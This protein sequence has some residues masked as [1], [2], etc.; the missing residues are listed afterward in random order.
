MD[1]ERKSIFFKISVILNSNKTAILF[2]ATVILAL[3]LLFPGV[4]VLFAFIVIIPV[5]ILTFKQGILKEMGFR[6]P[7]NWGRTI[8]TALILGIAI[9]MSFQLFFNP[10]IEYFTKVEI[11]LS[12]MDPLKG[13]L[14]NYFI[15]MIV[16]WIAGGVIEEIVFRGFLITR[17]KK[18]FGEHPVSLILIVLISSIPFGLAH[19]YQGAAGMWS[20][21]LIAIIL[22]IIFI[23]N[24]YNLWLPI[25]THGF[26]NTVGL[27]LIYFNWDIQLINLC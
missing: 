27:S 16:G 12:E 19:Q 14:T 25:L 8:L 4:G 24:N 10:I 13:N 11:D 7:E 3:I 18:V 17:L 20:T 9:E 22:G 2:L 15:M 6:K 26:I 5:I 1:E 23:K 21:G